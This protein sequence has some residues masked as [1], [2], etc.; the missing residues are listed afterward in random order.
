MTDQNPN[1]LKGWRPSDK[2]YETCKQGYRDF[3]F[4]QKYL[5][6]AYKTALKSTQL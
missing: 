5:E 6:D 2:Y 3:N 4:D 1:A